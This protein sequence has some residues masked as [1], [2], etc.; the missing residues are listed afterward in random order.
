M[1]ILDH[2]EGMP[3]FLLPLHIHQ[4][5]ECGFWVWQLQQIPLRNPPVRDYHEKIASGK[6]ISYQAT[7]SVVA[8]TYS[9]P[10]R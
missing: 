7:F 4:P 2:S 3:R 8:D 9:F 10:L 6:P 1:V 5:T